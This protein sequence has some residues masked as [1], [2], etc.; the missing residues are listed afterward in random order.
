M[1][2]L[3][4]SELT[5]AIGTAFC[6]TLASSAWCWEKLDGVAAIVD[7]RIILISEL[8][9]QIQLV[10]MQFS[11]DLSDSTRLDS[12]RNTLLQQMIDD[13]LV[14]IEAEKDTTIKITG[15][16]IEESLNQQIDRLKSQF[17]SEDAFMR[18]L[19]AEGLTLKSLRLRYREQVK[20]QLTKELYLDKMFAS[21]TISSG[22]TKE[23]YNTYRDS[24]PLLPAGY[25]LAQILLGIYPDKAV[26]DSLRRFAETLRQK[27]AAGEDFALIARTYSDDA[28]SQEGG[29]LGWFG[30]GD[31]VP[32]FDSAAFS[33]EPG[34]I[35]GV[36]Q[37]RFG[38]HII[39][40]L[41][42]KEDRVRASHVLIGFKPS[43]A[44]ILNKKHFADFLC[45]LL[46]QGADFGDLA[47]E[48]SEDEGSKFSQGDIGWFSQPEMLPEFREVVEKLNPGD[49]SPPIKTDYGWHII[50]I[51]DKQEGRPLDFVKDYTDIERLAKRHKT[52]KELQQWLKNAREKYYVQVVR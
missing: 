32:E 38:F 46:A 44:D 47:R 6:L 26:Q 5:L 36:V 48:Y 35:S 4:K 40:C 50:K 10:A 31:M 25:H 7:D 42:K 21:I 30:K 13:K 41:E 3:A 16:Q 17:P 8:E 20:N 22:E 34:Q 15:K 49:I 24:L 51:L 14:L 2:P 18:Q 12:L 29:E 33:L 37:T 9:S 27:I 19:A 39:K 11:L 43:T 45:D 1:I 52:Q 28:S 23:F